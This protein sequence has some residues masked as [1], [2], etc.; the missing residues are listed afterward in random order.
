MLLTIDPGLDA[1]WAVWDPCGLVQCGL[2]DP[3][4]YVQPRPPARLRDVWIERPVIYPRSKVPPN[5][6]VT[7]A[8]NA[9]RW[10]GIYS[11]LGLEVHFVEPATWKG[12]VPKNI[13]HRRIR[14][15]LSHLENDIVAKA[16]APL[17]PSKAHNVL[18]AVGLGLWVRTRHGV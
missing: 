2:G 3:R 12:Q 4:A 9:G 14:A 15:A 16:I 17:A 11:H 6:I 1:G 10:E 8:L 18:D 13:H 7:L 5:D